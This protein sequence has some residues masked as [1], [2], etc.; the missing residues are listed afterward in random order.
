[1]WKGYEA[2]SIQRATESA[3]KA[4]AP[5]FEYRELYESGRSRG[6]NAVS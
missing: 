1:M 3:A 6:V 2:Y 4:L 5:L